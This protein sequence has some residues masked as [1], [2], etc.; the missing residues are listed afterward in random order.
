M[1]TLKFYLFIYF[2]IFKNVLYGVFTCLHVSAPCVYLVPKEA[3]RG[4]QILWDWNNKV[5]QHMGAGNWIWL[6]WNSNW[7]SW[8]LS[9]LFSPFV[10]PFFLKSTFK[11]EENRVCFF[12]LS[13]LYN[14][15]FVSFSDCNYWVA[16]SGCAFPVT[17][18]TF[19]SV[20]QHLSK[21]RAKPFTRSL[22]PAA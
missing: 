3:R 2:Q 11:S 20:K 13:S 7:C 12:F 10:A 19:P 17:T 15:V 9:H 22:C 4:C 6:L 5:N 16:I 1:L 8:P 18:G 14:L 21:N